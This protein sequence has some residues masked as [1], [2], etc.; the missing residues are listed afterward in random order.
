MYLLNLSLGELMALFGVT[1][2]LITALYLLDRAR[3]RQ[4][5]AS[6]RFWTQAARLTEIRRR[7]RIREPLSLALQLLALALLLLAAAQVRWGSRE[8]RAED[9]VL[10]LD[11]SAWMAARTDSGTLMDRARELALGYLDALPA[12]D[13]VMLVRAEALATPVTAFETDRKLLRRAIEESQPAA[14]ALHLE[15]ALDFARRVQ[16]LHARR[17]GEIVYAGCA[18]TA[19]EPTS[20]AEIPRLRLLLV[21]NRIENAG[22]RKIGLR[23]SPTEADLWEM[24]VSVHN[25]G[26]RSRRLELRALLA[27]SPAGLRSLVLDAGAAAELTLPL[28][29]RAA[30][31][32]ELALEPGDRFPADDRARVELPAQ[33]SLKVLVYSVRP[34][35]LRAVFD[36]SPFVEAVYRSPGQVSE[37]PADL[38]VLD[39]CLPPAA[40]EAH[41]L[42]IEPPAGG[43]VPVSGEVTAAVVRAWNQS[44]PIAAGLNTQEFQLRSARVL[45]PIEGFDV[46]ASVDAGPVILAARDARSLRKTVVLGFDPMDGAARYQ[47]AAP[48]LAAN[49]LRWIESAVF[50]RWELNA[51]SVGTVELALGEGSDPDSIKVFSE[52][53]AN[54]PATLEGDRLRFYSGAPGLVRVVTRDR[55]VVYSMNLPEVATRRWDPPGSAVRGLPAPRMYPAPFRELWWP[56]AALAALLVVVEWLRFGRTRGRAAEPA[57]S[58]VSW[59]NGWQRRMRT[60]AARSLRRAS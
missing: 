52:T 57:R 53:G 33:R 18:R 25:Y 15:Q 21:E 22:I 10:L 38:V 5:V 27:G 16:R 43:P 54:L 6:L 13:R 20:A 19:D 1:A 7:R 47:L 8:D 11:T 50:R 42:W 40:L 45:T 26:V 60:L 35:R 2:A 59:I 48:L 37:E 4:V 51:G 29:T 39:R 28:R 36:A 23:H 49:I 17:P 34:E 12:G 32:V 14:G 24:Y 30:A 9:H 3:R 46:V 55:E 41:T 44:H 31:T 56:L 58:A